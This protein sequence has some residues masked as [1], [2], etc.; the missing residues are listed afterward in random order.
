MNFILAYP[1]FVTVH[2]VRESMRRF[3]MLAMRIAAFASIAHRWRN[4][5]HHASKS[6]RCGKFGL[7]YFLGRRGAPRLIGSNGL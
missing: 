6:F 3:K 2:D 5:F 7:V 1:G 4:F